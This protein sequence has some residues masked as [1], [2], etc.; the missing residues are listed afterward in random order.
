MAD[1]RVNEKTMELKP[2]SLRLDDAV[3]E[4]LKEITKQ[5]GGSQQD[6][7]NA[8]IN[9]Y[10]LAENKQRF[11]DH[12]ANLENFENYTS[13]LLGMY[14]QSLRA[15]YDMKAMVEERCRDELRSK[16]R[17]IQDL[18]K[19]LDSAKKTAEDAVSKADQFEK[20]ISS[21]KGMIDSYRENLDEKDELNKILTGSVHD[22][23]LQLESLGQDHEKVVSLEAEIKGLN[24]RIR[25]LEKELVE[26][27]KEHVKEIESY[28][29][30]YGALLDQQAQAA[31]KKA[32]AKKA[33]AKKKTEK[34]DSGSEAE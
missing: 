25:D 23:K 26:K 32:P 10:N 4:R 7:M 24:D 14:T 33:A 22:Q 15:N 19:E 28:L 5:I 27:D 8:L 2:R 30:K 21:L 13:Q 18:Q 17:T 29:Q 9:T 16:D 34:T 31:S 12:K 6:A 3:M 11:P 20:E 1:E